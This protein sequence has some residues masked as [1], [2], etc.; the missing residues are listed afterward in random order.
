VEAARL[1]E[2]EVTGAADLIV[3][4]SDLEANAIENNA[5]RP[6]LYAPP[7]SALAD[8]APVSPELESRFSR[9]AAEAGVSAYAA[10]IGSSCWPNVEGFFDLFPHGLGFLPLH[11]QIWVGGTLGPVLQS[12][13]R[14]QDFLSINA[15]RSRMLGFLAEEEKA[16]FFGAATCVVVPVRD[17]AGARLETADAIAS[18]RPVVITPQGL[19]GYG[20]IVQEATGRGV[21][22]ADTPSEFRALLRQALRGEA[23]GCTP[24]ICKRVRLDHLSEKLDH[25]YGGQ[26]AAYECGSPVRCLC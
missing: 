23:V 4:G 13:P 8:C 9:A 12:D 21:Y 10:M 5:L 19:E 17:G 2:L 22:V 1:R 25:A 6:V 16:A 7:A 14:F 20:S 18:G 11:Q 3:A 26:L 24:E 15:S